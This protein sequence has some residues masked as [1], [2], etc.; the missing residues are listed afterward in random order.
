MSKV[1]IPQSVFCNGVNELFPLTTNDDCLLK[2]EGT[3]TSTGN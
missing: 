1:W 2:Y 3:C